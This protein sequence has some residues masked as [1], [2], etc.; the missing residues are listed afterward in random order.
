MYVRI[1]IAAVVGAFIILAAL[2]LAP[3]PL[4]L[5]QSSP[6]FSDESVVSFR[7]RFGLTDTG[8]TDWSGTLEVTNGEVVRFSN[9]HPRP[10]D[11][12]I[13]TTSK[14]TTSWTLSTRPGSH[15][16][17]LGSYNTLK[18]LDS[19][20][21]LLIPGLVVDVKVTPGTR[22]KFETKQG[23]FDV[24]PRTLMTGFSGIL[25][26]GA[27]AVDRV[28]SA[29]RLSTG[30]YENDFA[31]ALGGK[32]GEI[33]VAWIAYRNK[34]SE[35]L[36]RR[37]DGKAWGEIQRVMDK[38][39][40]V[41][42]VRMGRDKQ[43]RPWAVWSQQTGG[44]WDLYGSHYS[45]GSWSTA[46]RLS[47][48]PQPDIFPNLTSDFNGN[49]WLVWQG[50]RNGS[51][52][53]FARR[54]DGASWSD[55]ERV[56]ASPANDWGPVITADSK[57]RVYVGWDSYDR[58]N[59]DVMMRSFADDKW[60]SVVPIANT[61]MFEAHVS[62]LCDKDDRLWAAWNESGVQWGKDTGYGIQKQGT[63]LY[64]SRSIAVSVYN[65]SGWDVP[66]SRLSRDFPQDLQ[67]YNDYPILQT[68]GHGRVWVF[69]RNRTLRF[70]HQPNEGNSAHWAAWEIWGSSYNG[71]RWR[72]P[73]HL[74]FS[75]N[76][77]DARGGF[78]N[79][80]KGNLYAAWVT[81]ARDFESFLFQHSDIYAARIPAQ[82]GVS[83]QSEF[84][85]R[86]EPNLFLAK[87]IHPNEA[88]DL[89]RIR[90]Y[91]I[92]SG[93]KTYRIYRGDTHRHT[94]FSFDGHNDGSLLDAYRYAMDAA[95]LD[96]LGVSEHCGMSLPDGARGA[97]GAP[98]QEYYTWLAQQTVDLLTLPKTFVPVYTYERSVSY[99]NGHRNILFAERGNPVL[100]IPPEE[101][102]GETGAQALF[103]YLRR[104]DGIAIPH[105]PT[106]SGTD[107]RD[108]DPEVQP[109]VEI[110]QGMRTSAEYAG[111]P[112]APHSSNPDPGPPRE[113][114]FLWSAWKKGLKIGVQASSDHTSTHISYACTIAEEFT[115][116]G[117]LDAMRKRHS[118]GA[119]DNIVLDYR[120]KADGKEYLQ[121]DEADIA[122][123]F[124]LSIHVIGTAAIRQIDI[125]KNNTFLHNRQNLGREVSFTFVDNEAESGESYYYVRV[126]QVDGEIAW[127]SPIWVNKR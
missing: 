28:P 126:I 81:D 95:S 76:R 52:D 65:G 5:S 13:G 84:K 44:N 48:D 22:M 40:D 56:S 108:A 69:F 61:P 83:K 112:R 53:V 39:G 49:L 7:V 103:E 67:E 85:A 82:P 118:Y 124:Q 113:A 29:E 20:P 4:A 6:T 97:A 57:G 30:D 127:S 31:T 68:G 15:R 47:D 107:Y 74:P 115:R 71:D 26:D 42:V 21:Y 89:K 104:Y 25:L 114:G 109:L 36:V 43:G 72:D 99:P 60:S 92:E 100:P 8:P 50:F 125:I 9:W 93:G 122:G 91:K 17:G 12:I 117:L 86:K 66:V 10:G 14:G 1:F 38:P 87:T 58:G 88:E 77:M 51:S 24:D 110:Y 2:T 70:R 106:G 80:S 34:A 16:R 46:K 119:T 23:S 3:S 101:Q 32:D 45:D 11:E 63:R 41:H 98:E 78:A 90:D 96:Y 55:E 37:F 35:V 73:L 102:R 94:E 64:E 27:V 19:A 18:S 59:Y 54:F 79:D 111:A 123:D 62:L 105:T 33:W 75:Q 116:D 121:G 120:L